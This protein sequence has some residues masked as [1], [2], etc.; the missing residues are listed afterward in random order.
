VIAAVATVAIIIR[1]GR[2]DYLEL[3]ALAREYGTLLIAVFL[4][5]AFWD[6]WFQR[7]ARARGLGARADPDEVGRP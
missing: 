4:A 7:T 6:Y 5:V 2:V 1:S 3:K